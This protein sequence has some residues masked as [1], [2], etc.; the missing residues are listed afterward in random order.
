MKKIILAFLCLLTFSISNA[1]SNKEIANVYIKRAYNV[2]GESVDFEEAKVLFEKAMKYMDTV[3]NSNVA[4]LGTEIY[5]ELNNFKKAREFSK[6]YFLLAKNKKSEEYLNQLELA[7]TIDEEI[8]LQEEEEKRIEEER[9]QKEKELKRIDSLKTIWNNKSDALSLKLDSIYTFNK[10]NLALY[11]KES[12]FGIISDKGEIVVQ[13]DEYEFAIS[14]DGFILLL[15]KEFEAT[16]IYCFNTANQSGFLLPSPSDLNPLSTHYG[17][18][19]LPRGNGRLVTYPNNSYQPLVYD[20][21]LKKIIKVVNEQDLLKSLKKTDKI[22]KYNKDGEVK[23]NK[24]WY[25]FGGHLGGG[26]HPLYGVEN[27]DLQSFLCSIDGKL[28]KISEY[29]YIGAFYNNKLQALNTG[30]TIWINQNGTKVAAPKDESGEYTGDSKVV[31]LDKGIYQI[32]QNNVIILGKDTLVK[33]PE[34][35]SNNA[36]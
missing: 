21:N 16:K 26:I 13:A 36:K 20:L 23:I 19:M 11:K 8:E 17:R 28:L 32:E 5:F 1:Q 22:D 29:Q 9:I 27:Y 14:Y 31:K 34:F 15:N 7:V 10:N 18:V 35:L 33:L 4:K 3:T 2:I 6:Q 12:N 30:K 25:T 24:V